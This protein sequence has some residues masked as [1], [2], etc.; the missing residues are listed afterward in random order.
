MGINWRYI[1]DCCSNARDAHV[2]AIV[3]YLFIFF[4]LGPEAVLPTE[5]AIEFEKNQYLSEELQEGMFDPKK[6][7]QKQ[8]IALPIAETPNKKLSERSH[9]KMFLSNSTKQ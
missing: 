1:I 2:E 3:K 6:E 7:C 8:V 9:M 4:F 5:A